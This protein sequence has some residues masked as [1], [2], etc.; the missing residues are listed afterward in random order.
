MVPKWTGPP[1]LGSG[2]LGG[3][4]AEEVP[5]PQRREPRWSL[6]GGGPLA[7]AVAASVA[8]KRRR[9]HRLSAG[10]LDGAKEQGAPSPQ[11]ERTSVVPKRRRPPHLSGG[12][13][14]GL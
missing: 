2:G 12:G 5:S 4:K 6:S 8:P 1:G 13:L 11:A 3:P 7:S 9:P 14:S 10:G